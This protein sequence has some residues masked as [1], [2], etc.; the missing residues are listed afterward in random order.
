MVY[1][2]ILNKRYDVPLDAGSDMFRK[3]VSNQG[4]KLVSDKVRRDEANTFRTRCSLTKW[5]ES[6]VPRERVE[7]KLISVG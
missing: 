1:V 2:S 6:S 5:N 7:Q 4:R 3:V